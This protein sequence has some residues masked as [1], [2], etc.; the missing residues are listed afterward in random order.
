MHQ[1]L[2]QITVIKHQLSEAGAGLV[3]FFR[4]LQKKVQ[5]PDYP[6]SRLLLFSRAW[7]TQRLGRRVCIF[8][9]R[10]PQASPPSRPLTH[11]HAHTRPHTPVHTHRCTH[12]AWYRCPGSRQQSCPPWPL[13]H[14]LG[15][16]D[17]LPPFPA[18]SS[19]ASSAFRPSLGGGGPPSR[20]LHHRGFL[21]P[22]LPK[23]RRAA[24]RR[25]PA[26]PCR[27]AGQGRVFPKAATAPEGYQGRWQVVGWTC[28]AW[29]GP[30]ED[31]SPISFLQLT[32]LALIIY[33]T[34]TRR[35]R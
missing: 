3:I 31:T 13:P 20:D 4:M 21:H 1:S 2:F 29:A 8:C 22:P 26:G 10:E 19:G 5:R 16:A 32:F 6:R 28:S 12:A 18:S 24:G 25:F 30:S 11:T 7:Q 23:S 14:G 9:G 15:L 34:Q 33:S 35:R 17:V 27:G